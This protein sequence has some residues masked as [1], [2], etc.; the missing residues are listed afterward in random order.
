MV[1]QC[2]IN[3][4]SRPSCFVTT[5]SI[6][7]TNWTLGPSKAKLSFCEISPKTSNSLIL[8]LLYNVSTELI[9]I[10]LCLAILEQLLAVMPG[11]HFISAEN[12]ANILI[13]ASTNMQVLNRDN[14]LAMTN[15]LS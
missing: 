10:S 4:I 2:L 11:S 6:Y 9:Y 1:S 13:S 5:N 8:F 12:G 3:S 15:L 7:I 14:A